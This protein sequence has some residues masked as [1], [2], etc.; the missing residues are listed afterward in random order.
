MII[1]IASEAAMAGASVE[2]VEIAGVAIGPEVAA[3][4]REGDL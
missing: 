1:A 4:G 3:P 2:A